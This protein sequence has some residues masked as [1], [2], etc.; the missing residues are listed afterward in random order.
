MVHWGVSP[1]KDRSPGDELD[2]V[3]SLWLLAALFAVTIGYPLLV[4]VHELGHALVVL[5]CGRSAEAAVGDSRRGMRIAIGRLGVSIGLFKLAGSCTYD[6]DGLTI[7]QRKN[8]VLGGPVAS[9]L[10]AA[11]L[12]LAAYLVADPSGPLFWL[13]AA[14]AAVAAVHAAD[15]AWP[16]RGRHSERSDGA[17]LRRLRSFEPHFVPPR[18]KGEAIRRL[19]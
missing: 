18:R 16:R 1:L 2:L 8:V 19:R 4:L 10:A 11:V 5:A 7:R 17:Q 12:A 14:G 13:L 15:T 9:A 3:T 6:S